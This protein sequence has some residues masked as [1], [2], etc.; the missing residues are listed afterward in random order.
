MGFFDKI[1]E[2]AQELGAQL[3]GAIKGTKGTAQLNSLN[4]QREEMARQLGFTLLDQFRTGRLDEVALRTEAERIFE[5]ERQ[6]MALQQQIE[7]ERQAA[8]AARAA[9]APSPSAAP[10]VAPPSPPEQPGAAP[11]SSSTVVCAGCGKDI[12]ADAAFCPECGV[13]R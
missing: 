11:E 3:D 4:R 1:K 13:R 12:P 7:A 10:P 6:I 9:S 5:V 8:A 2:Q